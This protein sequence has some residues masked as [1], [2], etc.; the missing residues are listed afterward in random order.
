MALVMIAGG[1][2]ALKV[3]GDKLL[4]APR[5]TQASHGQAPQQ[6][7]PP[8]AGA[9][10]VSPAQQ[11][12]TPV[13]AIDTAHAPQSGWASSANG[14]A[15][16]VGPFLHPQQVL[17]LTAADM[18]RHQHASPGLRQPARTAALPPDTQPQSSASVALP[19]GHGQRCGQM[20][21]APPALQPSPPSLAG[22]Q[23]PQQ[24]AQHRAS[25][26][27]H[28]PVTMAG[29]GEPGLSA[30][31]GAPGQP[32]QAAPASLPAPETLA[33]TSS[34]SAPASTSVIDLSQTLDSDQSTGLTGALR[35]YAAP[36][37]DQTSQ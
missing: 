24:Q 9:V 2:C 33:E 29:G 20:Q 7:L 11:Q 18:G 5:Q 27:Q 30:A 21:P 28:A 23:Q 3:E 17:Q 31:P 10:Q 19:A 37:T 13:T 8:A 34:P 26:Y 14:A 15:N 35:T 1:I 6:A 32:M 16:G 12:P 36:H 25:T 22:P 4:P